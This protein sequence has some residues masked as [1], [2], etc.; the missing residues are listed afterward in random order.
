[1]RGWLPSSGA[2]ELKSVKRDE[3]R[4]DKSFLLIKKWHHY[5]WGAVQEICLYW[6]CTNALVPL[7]T[8][9]F[10]GIYIGLLILFLFHMYWSLCTCI[11]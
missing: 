1:M 7:F 10:V 6:F 9:W 8:L 11:D 4:C 3:Q 2:S 5:V